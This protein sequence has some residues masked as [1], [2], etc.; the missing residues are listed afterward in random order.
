MKKKSEKSLEKIGER[1]V[2]SLYTP[3]NSNGLIQR[4]WNLR[5]SDPQGEKVLFSWANLDFNKRGQVFNHIVT[6]QP[7]CVSLC[8]L[9]K[10]FN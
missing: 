7:S 6:N 5:I 9:I 1:I 3:E 2:R 4:K 10:T 8:E